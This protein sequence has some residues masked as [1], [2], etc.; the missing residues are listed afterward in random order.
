MIAADLG[1]PQELDA[2]AARL[3]AVPE[4]IE[5]ALDAALAD[6]LPL[7]KRDGDAPFGV[8]VSLGQAF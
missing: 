6:E 5:R 7:N 8:Y 1:L 3:K 4:G 2:I